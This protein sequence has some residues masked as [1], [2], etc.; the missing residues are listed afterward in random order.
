[1]T[2]FIQTL[3]LDI[4]MVKRVLIGLF[5][6]LVLFFFI[7]LMRHTFALQESVNSMSIESVKSSYKNNVG[8]SFVVN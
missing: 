8:G 1:M 6:F 4:S 3:K 5:V 2:S 7:L